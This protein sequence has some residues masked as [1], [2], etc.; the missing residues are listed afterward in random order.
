[1]KKYFIFLTIVVVSILLWSE[2]GRGVF[3]QQLPFSSQ[4]YSN[5]FVVNPAYTGFTSTINAYLTH[6]SQWVS[7]PGAPQTSYLTVDGPL[8]TKNLGIGLKVYSYSTDIL[9]REGAFATYSYK[10]KVN[11]DNALRFGLALGMLANKIDFAKADVHDI[12]DPFLLQQQQNKTVFSADFGLLYTWK[13]L[14]AGFAVPQIFAGKTKYG[15]FS[16]DYSYYNLSRHYQGSI[17][18]TVEVSK[19][20]G[21]TAYPLIMFRSVSGAPFQYDV[22]AVVDWKKI[23]WFG[24]TY[25]SSYALAVSAGIRYKNLCLGYAY[26]IGMSQIKTYTGA[27]TEFLLGYVFNKKDPVL[28]DTTRGD[29]WAEQI[30]SSAALIKP[31]DYED[32]YWKSLN[33]NVDQQK[34]YNTIVEAVLSGKVQA[35]DL[36]TDSPLSITQVQTFLSKANGTKSKGSKKVTEKDLSKIRMSERWV[37]DKGRFT[38]VKQVYRIDLLIKRLDES[39]QYTG[40]DRPLFY[41]KLKR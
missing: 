6:R 17:K 10:I 14:E 13:K 30:Q 33:K 19:D 1:M 12:N 3:A 21:I 11:D 28:I 7:V 26:D 32:A 5:P 2:G 8:E 40:D 41:V 27:S 15:G 24:I 35:Y 23:G 36:V 29:I 31:E 25:H 16:G 34:I 37:F 22:N 4:Y 9:S 38:L 39:G 20:K 18:Y